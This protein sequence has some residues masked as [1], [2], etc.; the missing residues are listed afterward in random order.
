MSAPDPDELNAALL[1][2]ARDQHENA[3]GNFFR[4]LKLAAFALLG[5]QC[6]VFFPFTSL[7]D[8][9]LALQPQVEQAQSDERALGEVQQALAAFKRALSTGVEAVAAELR[10]VP[11]DIRDQLARLD[12]ELREFRAASE[13][14]LQPRERRI[15]Q[16][17]RPM[18]DGGTVPG[19]AQTLSRDEQ[20]TLHAAKEEDPAFQQLVTRVVEAEIIQPVFRRLNQ[21]V[22]TTL[23]QPLARE[24]A[25]LRGQTSA[26]ATLRQLGAGVDAWLADAGRVVALAGQLGFEPPA[27]R[28]WWTSARTKAEVAGLALLDTKRI[29]DEA[30][31][32]LVRQEGEL[33]SLAKKMETTLADL[34]QQ[35]AKLE[36]ESE[37]LAAT[38][39]SLQ[40]LM[41]GYA[42]PL[43]MIALNPRDLVL[44]Y[45]VALAGAVAMF[46]IRQ[47]LLRRRAL[48]LAGIYRRFG[49]SPEI[50]ALYFPELPATRPV[51]AQPA[52]RQDLRRRFVMLGWLAPV[53]LVGVSFAWVLVSASLGAEAPRLLYL[54]SAL[55]LAVACGFLW[56]ADGESRRWVGHG[57]GGRAGRERGQDG[58]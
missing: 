41:E 44:F 4:D 55:V 43:A 25:G 58:G 40:E 5:F 38:A 54:V 29:A 28:D 56:L 36:A 15:L 6:F 23:A 11:Q 16:Q 8:R 51:A 14:T 37:R 49:L 30:K 20:R 9:L 1:E 21:Q 12:A 26:L 2:R 24:L 31:A 32:S 47:L 42:K 19:F 45:P 39:S 34:H 46:A 7:S 13:T 22:D 48:A 50:L 27:Q 35:E 33:A 57:T 18:P 53:A 52:E 10:R 3:R 17:A